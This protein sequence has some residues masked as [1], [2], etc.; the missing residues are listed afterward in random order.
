MTIKQRLVMPLFLLFAGWLNA[1]SFVEHE[2]TITVPTESTQ[3]QQVIAGTL[4]VPVAVKVKVPA[5]ILITG[6]G[7]QDRDETLLDHKPFKVIAEQLSSKG[8]AVLR[9]DDRGVGGS[10]GDI[11]NATTLDFATDVEYQLDFLQS[12]HNEYNIDPDR[13]VLF[14]HS[15]GATVAAIVASRRGSAPNPLAGVVMLG[16]AGIN[17]KEALLQ[18]NDIIFHLKGLDDSLVNRRLDCMRELFNVCDTIMLNEEK[19]IV[20]QFSIAFRPVFK[21]YSEG[22]TKDQKKETGLSNIECYGWALTVAKPWMR[23]FLN[24]NPIHYISQM[25]CPLYAIWGDKDCQVPPEK[26]L[27]AI[28]E[29]CRQNNIPCKTVV[30]KGINHLGQICETGSVEEYQTLGQSP[31]DVVLE[32]IVRFLNEL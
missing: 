17:G 3:E 27:D 23:T 31:D 26:N 29:A 13:I 16:G 15:E 11:E 22:L 19:N 12:H 5:V 14:G 4:T 25:T 2:V 8:Y 6:S 1:Q 18:Q 20:R 28:E 21:K 30:L 10:T 32:T 24:L 9:C 7:A